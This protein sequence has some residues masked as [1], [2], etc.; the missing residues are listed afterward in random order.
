MF[1]DLG[2]FSVK[3]IQV[4]PSLSVFVY[5]IFCTFCSLSDILS[6]TTLSFPFLG[7]R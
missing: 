5:M 6:F 2:H 3:S 4:T 7:S 1:A